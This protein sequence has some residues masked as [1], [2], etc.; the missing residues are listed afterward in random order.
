MADLRITCINKPQM[1]GH[2]H[3]THVGNPSQ[4]WRLT[5]AQV[6]QSIESKLHTFHVIDDRSGARAYVGVVRPA[7]HAPYLR[8]YADGK[9]TNNL[10][11]LSQCSV[12]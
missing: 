12:V 10:L 3:I 5:T 4:S 8:T 1:G 11:S 9:W 7:N 2:E 6:V